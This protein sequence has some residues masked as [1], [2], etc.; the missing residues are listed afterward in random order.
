MGQ[1]V[2]FTPDGA[3]A[4]VE[5]EPGVEGFL[6]K[7]EIGLEAVK[8]ARQLLSDGQQVTARITDLKVDERRLRLTIRALYQSW[9]SVPSTHRGM[10]I[11][12]NGS[13]IQDI[14]RAT[15]TYI[16]LDSDSGQC[17]V[18]GPVQRA[19]QDAV[20]RIRAIIEKRVISFTIE[21]RQSG[22]II[23]KDGSMIQQIQQQTGTQIEVNRTQVTVIAPNE[24]TLGRTLDSIRAVISYYE[25]TMQVP[26]GRIGRVIGSGGSNIRSVRQQTDTWID[27][28][29]DSSGRI[30][31]EGKNRSNT[32]RAA[33]LIQGY[34]ASTVH[35]TGREAPI[36]PQLVPRR[37]LTIAKADLERL[38]RKQGGFFAMILGRRKS[39][40]DR[41]QASTG[42]HISTESSASTVLISGSS[43]DS[44]ERA[45]QEI[46]AAL[47]E[48]SGT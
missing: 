9:L 38:I 8:D 34:A 39:A 26:S 3:G 18:E 6:Y 43:F 37:Q 25:V 12:R 31:I 36:P 30:R 27:I 44:V 14:M 29:K 10:V 41:I 32:E 7:D 28:A 48:Q 5:L 46:D 2:G 23:G 20:Q 13:T 42:T 45:V 33:Q 24:T 17:S 19:V 40:I 1:V 47:K 4:F 35:F 21:D 16:N 22:M 15:G 11:G